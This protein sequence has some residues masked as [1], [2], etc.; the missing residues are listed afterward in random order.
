VAE[1]PD[2]ETQGGGTAG[3][4]E[5]SAGD[6]GVHIR[7]G[8]HWRGHRQFFAEFRSLLF[9]EFQSLLLAEF[10]SLL[11]AEFQSLRCTATDSTDDGFSPDTRSRRQRDTEGYSVVAAAKRSCV[12]VAH[13]EL[14]NSTGGFEKNIP[15][16]LL[17][18][19]ADG[20]SAE[21][22]DAV[23]DFQHPTFK[24]S[25]SGRPDVAKNN[26]STA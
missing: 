6:S 17:A 21:C 23:D 11:L 3:G 2:K 26:F 5:P 16:T 1:T 15:S 20:R 4:F 25:R 9:A 10:R 12:G 22:G 24:Y 19:G 14:R 8:R 13:A 18:S 7:L